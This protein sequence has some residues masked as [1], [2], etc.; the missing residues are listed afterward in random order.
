ML[1]DTAMHELWKSSTNPFEGKTQ[2]APSPQGSLIFE[3]YFLVDNQLNDSIPV[4]ILPD[5]CAHLIIHE[6]NHTEKVS[7]NI[8]GPRSAGFLI[9]RK[10]RKRTFIARFKPG[11]LFSILGTPAN[12]IKNLSVPLNAIIDFKPAHI[13]LQYFQNK[14]KSAGEIFKNIEQLIL[15]Y[16]FEQPNA[17][18]LFLLKKI[19]AKN[20]KINVNLIS[21]E[22]G[23]SNR[24][25][26]KLCNKYIGLTPKEILRVERFTKTIKNHL[27]FKNYTWTDV[28]HLSG[29]TDQSHLIADYQQ[30]I[31]KTPHKLFS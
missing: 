16:Y 24:Y 27:A 4:Y 25:L 7:L 26:Q 12:A 30:L 29:Y 23:F 5:L 31:G 19:K 9:N 20:D 21:Q 11:V 15:T 17:H 8:I 22:L 6:F 2:F 13:Y 28:A 3:N 18:I 10:N 14:K 1:Y